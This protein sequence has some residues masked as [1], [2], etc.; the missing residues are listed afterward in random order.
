MPPK[1]RAG[2]ARRPWGAVDSDGN[3]GKPVIDRT[4]G[5]LGRRLHSEEWAHR[6]NEY[7][8]GG[9]DAP[10]HTA[11]TGD[12]ATNRNLNSSEGRRDPGPAETVAA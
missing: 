4:A 8:A 1:F 7:Q 10:V 2:Y 11:P 6:H 9:A 12:E 5:R 3:P